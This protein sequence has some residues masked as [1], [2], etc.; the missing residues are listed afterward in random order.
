[1]GC[2]R[3]PEST[4]TSIVTPGNKELSR[5]IIAEK[6]NCSQETGTQNWNNILFSDESMSCVS[7]DIRVWHCKQEASPTDY[8]KRSVKLNTFVSNWRYMRTENL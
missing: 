8:L 3:H 5:R 6:V 7:Y 4:M 2:T 1:M